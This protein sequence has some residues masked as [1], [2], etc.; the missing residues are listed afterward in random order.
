M[1][2]LDQLAEEAIAQAR[3]RGDLDGLPGHGRPLD[4]GDDALVPPAL[5]P[6]YR[7]LKSAGYLPEEARLRGEIASAEALLHAARNEEERARASS[8]L[9]L[10]LDRL[11][12]RRAG[13][14]LTQEAYFQRIRNRLES[15]AESRGKSQP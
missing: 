9:R 7:L 10:L 6:A 12:G 2:L 13:S 15:R 3:E 11:G 5:R 4:L 8:Q 1:W 14:L